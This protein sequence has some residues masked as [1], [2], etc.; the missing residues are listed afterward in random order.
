LLGARHSSGAI[1]FEIRRMTHD[2]RL[3]WRAP[4]KDVCRDQRNALRML[5]EVG[6]SKPS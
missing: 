2:A 6:W 5:I 4:S 3:E 1:I